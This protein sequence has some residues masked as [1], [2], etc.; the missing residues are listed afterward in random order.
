MGR[1][2]RKPG[3]KDTKP[4]EG[5]N[6]S[7]DILENG[8]ANG[9]NNNA[10]THRASREAKEKAADFVKEKIKKFAEDYELIEDPKE[11]CEIFIKMMAFVV[12]KMT[13]TDINANI[14]S[15]SIGDELARLA[16]TTPT[17]SE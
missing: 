14:E 8:N 3:Q 5:Y 12:P 13:S 17:V 16:R 1:T 4:R 2:G 6:F 10:K 11:R 15:E 9:V 7:V